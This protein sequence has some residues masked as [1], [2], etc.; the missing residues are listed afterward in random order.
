MMPRDTERK[1]SLQSNK[2]RYMSTPRA[3]VKP[4]SALLISP[5]AEDHNILGELFRCQGWTLGHASS[6]SSVSALLTENATSVVITERDLSVGNWKDVLKA[7]HALGE[8]PLLIV[9]SRLADD[10]LWAEALNLG[11]YDVLAKPL[12]H[13]EV[14]RVLSLALNHRP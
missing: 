10:Y 11:V 3:S 2:A 1:W 7:M 5:V 13:T 4:Q 8:P 14:V 6:I 12:D 9:I